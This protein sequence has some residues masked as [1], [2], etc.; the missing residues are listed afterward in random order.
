MNSLPK[1]DQNT[2]IGQKVPLWQPALFAFLFAVAYTQPLV[3][4]SNQNQYFLHP[5]A[6]LGTG[7]LQ[8]DWLANTIDPTPVFSF[9]MKMSWQ[10]SGTWGQQLIFF[11]AQ[12]GYFLAIWSILQSLKLLPKSHTGRL[13]FAGLFIAS[14]AAIFRYG[15]DRLLGA[16]YFWF[17]QTGL[18][19][20]YLLGAGL[21]PSVSGVLILVAIAFLCKGQPVWACTIAAGTNILHATYLLPTGVLVFGVIVQQ[22]GNRNWRLGFVCAIVGLAIAL[23]I[24]WFNATRFAPT[25]SETFAKAQKI[26]AHVRIPHH[27]RPARWFDVVAGVQCLGMVVA[28]LVV[29]RSCLFGPMFWLL[30]LTG[31]GIL[32]AILTDH[33]TLALVFPWRIT[34]VLVPLSSAIL[35]GWF[36]KRLEC[37]RIPSAIIG[38]VLILV[39]VGGA[40]AIYQ[41]KLGY[42]EPESED[43][44]LEYVKAT[45]KPD[46]MYLIPARFPKPT[47]ARGVYSNT[48]A[49][50][51][52]PDAIVYFELARFRLFT[53]APMFIDFKSMPYKDTDILEWQRRVAL[54]EKWYSQPKWERTTIEELQHEGITHVIVPKTIQIESD[55]LDLKKNTGTYSVYTL[56]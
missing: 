29:R 1:T 40:F 34:A 52:K 3:F 50:P 36:T 4:Y 13:L 7:N 56:K 30:L 38:G 16:D 41:N 21:Q 55:F 45:A 23:P 33:P 6:E 53:G 39:G 2:L 27:T 48:F 26:M 9:L 12:M 5:L 46:E 49:Q 18:A 11:V 20:Q 19:N 51:P 54:C 31:G 43:S 35:F 37:C 32:G 24:V 25:D 47:T 14:H 15:S 8:Q 17:F 44:L 22:L 10:I 28:W 42:R